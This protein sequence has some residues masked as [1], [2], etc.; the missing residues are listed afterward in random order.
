MGIRIQPRDIE[1]PPD[2]PF[3]N[4]LL[5]RKKPIEVLT[6][7]V[8]SFE[9]PCVLAVDAEW[10]NGKTT[11]LKI[12][13][14]YLRNQQFPIVE[15]NAWENDFSED[16]FVTLS[17][18]L[19]E[20]LQAIGN[21][22]MEENITEVKKYAKEVIR[23]VIPGVIRFTTASVLDISPLFEK[24]VGSALASYAEEKLS[25]YG[26]AKESIKKFRRALQDIADELSEKNDG[27]PLV[28]II[29][30]LDRCRPSYAV[31]LLEV[32]KHLFT[33]D[34]VVFVLAVNR[35]ELAN[36]VTA[37]YGSD[38]DAQEYLRRFFDVDFRLPDPGQDTFIN[39]MLLAI[40]IDDYFKRTKDNE[41]HQ[42]IDT[43]RGLLYYF[44]S[45]HNLS[46]RTIAQSIHCLGLVFAS[47][48]NNRRSFMLATVVALI[49]RTID[50]NLYY[51]F[52]R[53]E[54]S[55]LE[56]V[57]KIFDRSEASSLQV[58]QEPLP[59]EAI[60]EAIV[61]IAAQELSYSISSPLY[62]RYQDMVGDEA[63]HKVDRKHAKDV[64][65]LI[66]EQLGSRIAPLRK[67]GFIES[68]ER[69]E[70]LSSDLLPRE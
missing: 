69:L 55:D 33:V 2:D 15:F 48:G 49:L 25:A 58:K 64:I 59:Y 40:G 3:K 20:G 66:G 37:L 14:Q 41:V 12:W 7:L 1:V 32:A 42:E 43:I 29:D 57:N 31:E 22:P 56:V 28:V 46:L 36:S 63:A 11:F 13:A 38:F 51:R 53:R 6:H 67:I 65:N 9:G 23:R 17:T 70:L 45:V 35:S 19:T 10:G 5:G 18:E 68:V 61:I 16:P 62:E 24:E 8:G 39:G 54:I 26:K 34:H 30:E 4:D 50:T 44:F 47:L 27:K 60:F 21:G 52:V